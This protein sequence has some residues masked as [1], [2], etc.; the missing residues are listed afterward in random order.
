MATGYAFQRSWAT[1]TT[2]VLELSPPS[3]GHVG[4]ASL[5]GPSSVTVVGAAFGAG[6]TRKMGPLTIAPA[7]R[8]TRW[9]IRMDGVSR[10]QI[11]ILLGLWF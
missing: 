9:S 4:I 3:G 7:F 1:S 10:N 8:Y 5:G 2:E 6:M 11:E